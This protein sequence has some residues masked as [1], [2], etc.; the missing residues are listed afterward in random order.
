[1]WMPWLMRMAEGADR[2]RAESGNYRG[3]KQIK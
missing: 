2:V 3:M 1:M